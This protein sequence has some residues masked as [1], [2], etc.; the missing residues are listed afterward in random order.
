MKRLE[1]SRRSAD[2][3]FQT[4]TLVLS[5]RALAKSTAHP[6]VVA[7]LEYFDNRLAYRTFLV[8]H[9]VGATDFVLWAALKSEHQILLAID[10]GDLTLFPQ[11]T[12]RRSVF[13]KAANTLTCSDCLPTSTPFPPPK[14]L[15][16]PLLNRNLKQ[17]RRTR[18]LLPSPSDF[19]ARRR[20]RS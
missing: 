17:D 8:G 4:P 12:S 1:Y 14:M 11:P 10:L 2:L 15:S 20:V 6:E 5:A 18:L 16:V 3:S 7:A 19:R 13:L 9:D